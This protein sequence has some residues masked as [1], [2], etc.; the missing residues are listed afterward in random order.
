[1]R[2]A[3]GR[4][5]NERHCSQW[6]RLD[7]SADR[8]PSGGA[9]ASGRSAAG[10]EGNRERAAERVG[11]A[12]RG[13]ESRT[14]LRRRSSCPRRS[15][16]GQPQ[17]QANTQTMTF[18]RNTWRW[19]GPG[20]QWRPFNREPFTRCARRRQMVDGGSQPVFGRF[21]L[22]LV[23]AERDVE[24][25]LLAAATAGEGGENLLDLGQVAFTRAHV[26][27]ARQFN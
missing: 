15:R 24:R 16:E 21:N 23:V 19:T 13:T 11:P 18:G 7:C 3:L 12:G 6:C 17:D 25:L 22:F 8:R 27:R 2:I 20:T 5:G 1:M 4:S 14:R 9:G 26:L 10:G